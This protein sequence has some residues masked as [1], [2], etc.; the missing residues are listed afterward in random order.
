M[1]EMARARMVTIWVVFATP[2][3]QVAANQQPP[4]DS[5]ARDLQTARRRRRRRRRGA[6]AGE[7][8][9]S[10]DGDVDL[11]PDEDEWTDDEYL[12]DIYGEPRP[13]DHLEKREWEQYP[14]YD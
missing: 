5:S 11:D 7:E 8:G 9:D 10:S 12:D 14:N 13:G 6:G 3:L 2:M 4:Q 1:D